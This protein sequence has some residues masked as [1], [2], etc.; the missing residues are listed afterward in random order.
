MLLKSEKRA[1]T[2]VKYIVFWEVTPCAELMEIPS[3]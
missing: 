3:S 2:D 1:C